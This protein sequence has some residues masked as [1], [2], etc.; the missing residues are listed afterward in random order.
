M[1]D[2][3]QPLILADAVLDVNDVISDLQIAEVGEKRGDLG[4]RSLRTRCD[5]FGFVEE[6]AGSEDGEIRVREQHTIGDVGRGE[7]GGEYFTGEITGFVG[8]AF[9]AA[10]AASETEGDVVFGEDVGQTLDLADIGDREEDAFTVAVE[11]LHF[12]EHRGNC[13]MEAG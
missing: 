10:S 1:V 9:A 12:F 8:V 4:F 7:R 6:V 11:F 13:A 5:G 2:F 3:F